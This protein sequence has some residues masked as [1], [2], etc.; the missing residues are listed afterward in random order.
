MRR[1]WNRGMILR[2][3]HAGLELHEYTLRAFARLDDDYDERGEE[4][5]GHFHFLWRIGREMTCGGGNGLRR[6]QIW[7][8]RL[9]KLIEIRCQNVDDSWWRGRSKGN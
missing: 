8:R 4:G 5:T 7:N 1:G 9:V 3:I 2:L 6:W